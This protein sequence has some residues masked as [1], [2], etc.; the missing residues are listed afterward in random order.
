MIVDIKAEGTNFF[1]TCI[2]ID[3]ETWQVLAWTGKVR[4]KFL[5]WT[6]DDIKII[7][8]LSD[9]DRLYEYYTPSSHPDGNLTEFGY[10][11]EMLRAITIQCHYIA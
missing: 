2:M 6:P 9:L 1:T 5:R 8:S 7:Y 4:A 11:E 3:G 10:C